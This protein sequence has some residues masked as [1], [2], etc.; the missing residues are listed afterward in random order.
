MLTP[1]QQRF[2][3]EFVADPEADGVDL[4][5]RAGFRAKP[6]LAAIKAA[7]LLA[8]PVI[9]SAIEVVRQARREAGEELPRPK[10][11]SQE[12]AAAI[13]A[14]IADGESLR[15][16]CS[17][18]EM[19]CT[20][21]VCKW[22]GIHE[23]FA[24]H[25]A[26]ARELQADAIFDE[27]LDIADDGRNDWVEKERD[28]GTKYEAFNAEHVQRSKLRIDARKWMA[29]K[30]RPKK[31]GEATTVKHADADG[32]KLPLDEVAKFTRLAAMADQARSILEGGDEPA[33]DAG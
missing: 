31:Y 6:P 5:A 3:E 26:R 16:I 9:R 4:Y 2:V 11:Y 29:G 13:C 24:E 10:K 12:L 23:E 25:Y 32:E 17:D 7:A 1:K 8:E 20:A 28:D 27:I 18:P 22:L 15:S 21:S 19:P 14:R 30:L 33:D